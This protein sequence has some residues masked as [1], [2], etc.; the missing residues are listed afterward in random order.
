MT[1][2]RFEDGAIEFELSI[3]IPPLYVIR[4]PHPMLSTVQNGP[5]SAK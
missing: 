2:L 3:R 5:S 1:N 4:R